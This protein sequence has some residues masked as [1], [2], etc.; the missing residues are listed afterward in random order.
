[1][2]GFK[3][4]TT[5]VKGDDGNWYVLELCKPLHSLIDMTAEFYGYEG[6]RE[7]LT[8]ITEGE[9]TPDSINGIFNE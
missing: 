7:V 2:S 8:F 5:L 3:Y 9:A 4:M 6:A 1:M